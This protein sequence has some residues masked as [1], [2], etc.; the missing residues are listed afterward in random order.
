MRFIA[1]ILVFIALIFKA[2]SQQPD[3]AHVVPLPLEINPAYAG[4]YN[5]YKGDI[6]YLAQSDDFNN[7]LK[8]F[9]ISGDLPLEKL[10]SGVGLIFNDEIT[11]TVKSSLYRFTYSYSFKFK[12]LN[13]QFGSGISYLTRE[14]VIST[15]DVPVEQDLVSQYS[16][17]YNQLTLSVGIFIY[18]KKSFFSIS[19]IDIGLNSNE[20]EIYP[21][22]DQSLFLK[23]NLN[24][25]Y[26]YHFF[27]E[28]KFS[29]NPGLYLRIIPNYRSLLEINLTTFFFNKLYFSS[30]YRSSHD[31]KLKIGV[32]IWKCHG[33]IS[34]SNNLNNIDGF[35]NSNNSIF[36][37]ST[38]FYFNNK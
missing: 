11:S 7:N 25:I 15:W 31:V 2:Y 30:A 32:N 17:N 27:K 18:S 23:S 24:I 36:E 10:N 33:G 35:L 38:G 20:K 19:Y 29:V 8:S 1:T 5:Q 6:N 21:N 26:S 14:A 9:K 4:S 34:Y 16:Q 13:I 22:V 37:L 12:K 28:K 3:I